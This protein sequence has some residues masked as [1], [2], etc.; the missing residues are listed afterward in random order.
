[1]G[2]ILSREKVLRRRGIEN[3]F[4]MLLGKTSTAGGIILILVTIFALISANSQFFSSIPGIWDLKAD[5]AIGNFKLEM[6]LLHWVNDALMAI[7]FFVVGLEIKR[8]MVVGELSTLKKATLPIFA[9]IGGM[10]TPA[11][12]FNFFNAGTVSQNGWGIPMATDIAFS[13]GVIALLGRSVPMSLK[14]FL[15]ALAIVDDIGAIIV[16]AVF[17]PSHELHPE[18]LAYSIAIVALLVTFNRMNLHNAA[19]YLIPGLFLWYFVYQSGVHATIAGVILAMCIPSKSPI[20]E[21]RFYVRSKYYLE[22]FKQASNNEVSIL[23]NQKQLSIIHNLHNHLRQMNPLINRLEHTIN[24]YITFSI[25]PIFALANAGV[26]LAGNPIGDGLSPLSAGIFFGLLF[27][28]PIGITLFTFIACKLKIA[29]IPSD[30]KWK[31]IF[32]V[33]IIAGIGF[34]MS[35]FIDSLAFSNEAIIDEGKMAIIITSVVAAVAGLISLRLSLGKPAKKIKYKK[36]SELR[37][38]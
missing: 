33:G 7:F 9:A 36:L 13:L 21:V 37:N 25:M 17:Y 15:T 28:K 29:E 20:N 14:I 5:F 19:L 4:S 38:N 1:M 3:V 35:I 23:A 24:P 11:L 26:V 34:T 6:T 8:E 31:Q 30:I 22:K 10:L 18:F 32:S 2:N 27:G 12:I 16:L